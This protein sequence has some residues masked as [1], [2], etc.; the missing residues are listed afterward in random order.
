M[1]A[2]KDR[3]LIVENDPVISDFIG[4]QALSSAGYQVY[5]V[6]DVTSAITKIVQTS[7]DLIICD[8][9]L[10]GLSGKDL[11][12]A[13]TA[14]GIETPVIVIAPEGKEAE[15]I[16]TFRLGASDYLTWPMREAEILRAAER[17]LKQVHEQ[18]NRGFLER[19]L[20]DTNQQLQQRVRELTAIFSMGKAVT[21]ITD[22]KVLFNKIIQVACQVSY[23]DLGWFLMREEE[24]PKTF[25]LVAQHQLPV[26][27]L[28]NLQQAWDDGISSLVAMSGETLSMH[29]EPIKRFR[30]KTLGKS[31]I[32]VPI[33]VQ[34]QV[35]GILVVMRTHAQPFTESEQH[36]LEAVADYASIS[37]VNSRLFRAIEARAQAL[38]DLAK[39]TQYGEKITQE[40]LSTV[41]HHLINM[42]T[43][44]QIALDDLTKDPT[45]RWNPNQR[46][47]L[48]Q[49]QEGLQDVNTVSQTIITNT[50]SQPDHH[51][52]LSTIVKDMGAHFL[53]QAQ[54]HR[55]QL[56]VEVPNHPVLVNVEF[57]HL[58]EIIKGLI[59]NALQYCLPQG[60]IRLHVTQLSNT[61]AQLTVSNSGAIAHNLRDSIFRKKSQEQKQ[62]AQRFGGI[63]ISLELIREL[64]IHYDGKISIDQTQDNGTAFRIQLPLSQKMID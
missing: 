27:M 34:R 52:D 11:M 46:K 63:G 7:P 33:K 62:R 58:S 64:I 22:Q 6:G 30:V 3:I 53:P 42:N 4:R 59:S 8:I 31:I 29:G 57:F 16:Q 28:D 18:R 43:S 19:K 61:T 26:S 1:S 51:T 24:K 41:H 25:V 47:L 13:L 38:E 56:V 10:P 45:A 37:L 50:S 55:L 35:M 2:N 36:L 17:I 48:T 5:T 40:L 9:N 21:S 32:I 44:S 20:K 60:I 39:R 23:G 54:K 12:V 49:L 14:Q 15:V